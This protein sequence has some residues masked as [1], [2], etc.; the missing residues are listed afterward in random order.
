M[1]YAGLSLFHTV[2]GA[3]TGNM[4]ATETWKRAALERYVPLALLDAV[5]SRLC[6]L[7]G[8]TFRGRYEGPLGV[9]MMIVSRPEGEGFAL[10]PCVE[11][12]VRRTMGHV[13]LA[14]SQMVNPEGDDERLRVMRI[15]Y[16]GGSYK[17]RIERPR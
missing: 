1:A 17:L 10:H 4:L 5:Q 13:A 7:I 6:Q 9:D 16:E 3:Y 8:T 12:N 11:V 2:N 15:D 14:L